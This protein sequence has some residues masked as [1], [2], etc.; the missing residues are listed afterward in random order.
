MPRRDRPSRARGRRT[1]GWCR[2]PPPARTSPLLA[3]SRPSRAISR[4]FSRMPGR[5]SLSMRG[6]PR[7][8]S[9][10]SPQE[11][12]WSVPASISSVKSSGSI[13]P[14]QTGQRRIVSR[15][16]LTRGPA[17]RM[18]ASNSHGSGGAC[19]AG[20]PATS[21]QSGT[22]PTRSD[23]QSRGCANPGLRPPSGAQGA[24]AAA[25]FLPRQQRPRGL[26]RSADAREALGVRIEDSA[27]PVGCG[28]AAGD[29]VRDGLGL[30][31]EDQRLLL[32]VERVLGQLPEVVGGPGA[33]RRRAR[34]ARSA[35]RRPRRARAAH[36]RGPRTSCGPRR[37][38]P[39]TGGSAP[40]AA[41]PG[42]RTTARR[43]RRVEP[44]SRRG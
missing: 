8:T 7:S 18:R 36:C 32:R 22:R 41:A 24:S 10:V 9:K 16:L 6:M 1:G 42:R 40:A 15:S 3:P 44:P 38:R 43:G 5:R 35:A 12:Q 29:E 13:A 30:L 34:A 26:D 25:A 11:R 31:A 20:R 14:R 27:R 39:A 28:P 21:L 4:F 23:G 17:T 33:G 37:R 19:S 2:P